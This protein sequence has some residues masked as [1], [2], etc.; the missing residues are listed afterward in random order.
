MSS[1][2]KSNK[3]SKEQEELPLGRDR[4]RTVIS[5][6]CNTP[7]PFFFESF[8]I[9]LRNVNCPV[10][11]NERNPLLLTF[12]ATSHSMLFTNTILLPF[13]QDTTKERLIHV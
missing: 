12:T 10:L 1:L 6:N 5:D 9:I 7:P 8:C 11:I 2:A 3:D 13:L 4:C